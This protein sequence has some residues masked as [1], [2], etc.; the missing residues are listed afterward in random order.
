ML[1]KKEHLYINGTKHTLFTLV[2]VSVITLE[3]SCHSPQGLPTVLPENVVPGDTWVFMY[4]CSWI[5]MVILG[6]SF[7]NA[8]CLKGTS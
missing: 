8:C 1:K 7:S 4:H 6:H 3:W 2:N 5:L